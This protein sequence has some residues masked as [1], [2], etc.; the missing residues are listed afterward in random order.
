MKLLP[1]SFNCDKILNHCLMKYI[2]A[3]SLPNL[4]QVKWSSYFERHIPLAYAG[5]LEVFV[6]DQH[7]SRVDLWLEH[8]K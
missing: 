6:F 2:F 8:L 4:N 1:R 7:R 5:C 3:I